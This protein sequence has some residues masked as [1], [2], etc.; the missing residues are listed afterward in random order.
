MAQFA[1]KVAANGRMVIPA[2]VRSA[3]GLSQGGD[4]VLTLEDGCVRI[5]TLDDAIGRAQAMVARYV[6]KD[7]SLVDELI[8][9]RR[10]AA[11]CAV[12]FEPK[13]LDGSHQAPLV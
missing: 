3:L 8:A 5:E 7:V 1:V 2:P 13:A 6:P 10:L 11:Q 12:G 9:E 4:V